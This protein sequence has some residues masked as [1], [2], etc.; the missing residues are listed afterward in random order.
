MNTTF[1]QIL[2]NCANDQDVILFSTACQA[3]K[4]HGLWDDFRTDYGTLS[5]FG[6]IN[7]HEFLEWLGY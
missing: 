6:G 1:R 7:V 3:A 2:L 4:E 5:A